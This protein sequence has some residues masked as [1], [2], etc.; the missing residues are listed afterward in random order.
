VT[1]NTLSG[2]LAINDAFV[3]RGII[4]APFG[5][6]GESGMGAYSASHGVREFSH[7]RTVMT[8]TTILDVPLR[9]PPYSPFS[10]AVVGGLLGWS[11]PSLSW[12]L[13]VPVGIGIVILALYCSG[14]FEGDR[15]ARIYSAFSA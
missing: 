1:T 10:Q 12:K 8:N 7:N 9:Y 3:Q 13:G 5:G 15:L 14:Y 2:S 6:V 11:R 4:A